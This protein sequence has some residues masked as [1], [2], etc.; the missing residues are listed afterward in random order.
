MSKQYASVHIASGELVR[1]L[2]L[3]L[4]LCLFLSPFTQLSVALWFM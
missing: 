2:C 3:A 4:F 1:Y